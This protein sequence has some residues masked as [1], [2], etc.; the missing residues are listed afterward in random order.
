MERGTAKPGRDHHKSWGSKKRMDIKSGSW[1]STRAA[2]H[3][4]SSTGKKEHERKV[5]STISKRGLAKGESNSQRGK[6]GADFEGQEEPCLEL[7]KSP[8][9]SIS[10]KF[11]KVHKILEFEQERWMKEYNA[12]HNA[13]KKQSKKQVRK[14][15]RQVFVKTMENLRN[16]TDIWILKSSEEK[17]MM[18]KLISNPLYLR[19]VIFSRGLNQ[20]ST[21]TN[22]VLN[23]PVYVEMTIQQ[24]DFEVW[25][26]LQCVGREV[27]FKVRASMHGHWQSPDGGGEGRLLQGHGG[28]RMQT[29]ITQWTIPKSISSKAKKIWKWCERWKMN[30]QEHRYQS[31]CVWGRKCI[32]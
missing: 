7:Q 2:Q 14:G 4:S 22:L 29:F 21:C 26:L 15:F 8:K 1:I 18:W 5:A 16:R 31:V 3:L 13:S 10:G 25:L 23:K 30:V 11:K 17:R 32:P 27:W 20:E 28:R 24:Q 9:I 12:V 6:V 19:H